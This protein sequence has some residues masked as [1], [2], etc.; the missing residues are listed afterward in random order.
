VP[1]PEL[2]DHARHQRPE[3]VPRDGAA[4]GPDQQDEA[5]PE[6]DAADT[7]CRQLEARCGQRVDAVEDRRHQEARETTATLLQRRGT[8]ELLEMGAAESRLQQIRRPA[9]G[10]VGILVRGLQ[11]LRHGADVMVVVVFVLVFFH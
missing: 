8:V 1:D 4:L 3:R 6:E 2:P 5:Q 9:P 10:Q 11:P 7:A